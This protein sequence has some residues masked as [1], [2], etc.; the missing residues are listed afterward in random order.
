MFLET[1]Q[2]LLQIFW[3]KQEQNCFQA[4]KIPNPSWKG[5]FL[6]TKVN[7]WKQAKCCISIWHQESLP[8]K[9]EISCMKSRNLTKKTKNP[10]WKRPKLMIGVN[11]T[12]QK[13]LKSS[14]MVAKMLTQKVC[15]H[16]P[17]LERFQIKPLQVH[18][19]WHLLHLML[20]GKTR[21]LIFEPL[22]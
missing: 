13:I 10:N 9:S 18:L 22:A 6:M 20:S 2:D 1:F 8:E 17:N 14:F 11:L 15:L 4:L 19:L 7:Q 12:F 16:H 3:K 5:Q 21:K